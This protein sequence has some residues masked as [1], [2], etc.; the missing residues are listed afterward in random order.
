MGVLLWIGRAFLWILAAVRTG[1]TW[2]IDNV[3]RV[4]AGSKIWAQGVFVV[5]A[6]ALVGLFATLISRVLD[7]FISYYVVSAIDY[8]PLAKQFAVLGNI[9]KYDS[10]LS[11][12]SFAFTA[13]AACF[14]ILVSGFVYRRF[15]H[16]FST[17]ARSWRL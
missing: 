3:H 9:I 7:Y 13:Y 4:V 8:S 14:N 15:Y 2:V 1:G 5:S 16:M 17:A 11:I 6:V 10:V 12:F